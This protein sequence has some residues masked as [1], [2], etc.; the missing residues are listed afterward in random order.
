VKAKDHSTL[1]PS[2]EYTKWRINTS[3]PG[4]S[5][6]PLASPECLGLAWQIIPEVG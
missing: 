2:S 5:P 1:N 3:A 6:K 4:P